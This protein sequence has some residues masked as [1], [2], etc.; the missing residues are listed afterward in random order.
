MEIVEAD[1]IN[2]Q[3]RQGSSEGLMDIRW[4]TLYDSTGF[5]MARIEFG[6]EE[7]LVTSPGLLEPTQSSHSGNMRVR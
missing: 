4:V 6:S 1:I 2:S 3:P 7:D 5:S